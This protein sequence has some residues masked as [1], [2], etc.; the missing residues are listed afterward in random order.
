M[1]L[2]SEHGAER[3]VG[4]GWG[5]HVSLVADMGPG[6][7]AQAGLFLWGFHMCVVPDKPQRAKG[8]SGECV[9][10]KRRKRRF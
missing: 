3:P 6:D 8:T 2:S 7:R 1:G 9:G 10:P 4:L 5:P